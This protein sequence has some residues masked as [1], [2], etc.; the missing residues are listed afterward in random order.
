MRPVCNLNSFDEES[1]KL[2]DAKFFSVFNATKGLFHLLLNERSKLTP[3][4]VYI[5]NVLT[6]GLSNSNDPFESASRELL[7]GLEGVVNITDGILVFGSTQ[8][9]HNH[10]V[11]V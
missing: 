10:N 1:F 2:K 3:L 4:G 7:Q 8:Q 11:I 6:M 5:F 9:E